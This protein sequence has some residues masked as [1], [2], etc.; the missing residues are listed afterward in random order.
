VAGDAEAVWVLVCC[1]E[2]LERTRPHRLR[3]AARLE[4]GAALDAMRKIKETFDPKGILNP[5]KI[6]GT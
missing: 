2:D 3:L 5:G 4:H 6:Y 1:L